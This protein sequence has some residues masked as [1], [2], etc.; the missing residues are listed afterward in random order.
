MDLSD[1]EVKVPA[2]IL[3]IDPHPVVEIHA[4]CGLVEQVHSFVWDG[5]E[6]SSTN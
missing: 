5:G 3:G 4:T 6:T 2:W 1:P